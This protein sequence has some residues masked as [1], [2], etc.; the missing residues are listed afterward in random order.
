MRNSSLTL[1]SLQDVKNLLENIKPISLKA[2]FVTS[3]FPKLV[4]FKFQVKNKYY[5]VINEFLFHA[6]KLKS[7]KLEEDNRSPFT[8]NSFK[9][10]IPDIAGMQVIENDKQLKELFSKCIADYCK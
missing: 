10:C 9:G 6:I 8:S 2:C 3:L 4:P 7:E 5:L 1:E